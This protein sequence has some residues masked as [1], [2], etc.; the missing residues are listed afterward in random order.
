[1]ERFSSEQEFIYYCAKLTSQDD[2]S[3]SDIE[4]FPLHSD[5]PYYTFRLMLDTIPFE[6]EL[7]KKKQVITSGCIRLLRSDVCYSYRNNMDEELLNQ[8]VEIA[9]AA[10][11]ETSIDPHMI[12]YFLYLIKEDTLPYLFKEYSSQ[13]QNQDSIY[14]SK[15]LW[16]ITNMIRICYK[17]IDFVTQLNSIIEDILT[18]ITSQQI[19]LAVI[20]KSLSSF[21]S[22]YS[23]YSQNLDPNPQFHLLEI[24]LEYMDLFAQ[25]DLIF[26]ESGNL[27]SSISY[28]FMRFDHHFDSIIKE[29]TNIIHSFFEKS[30]SLLQILLSTENNS[31]VQSS[32][33]YVLG[34]L[35]KYQTDE[36]IQAILPL[37]ILGLVYSDF[38]SI[39]NDPEQFF[40]VLFDFNS[41]TDMYATD[42]DLR[43]NCAAYLIKLYNETDDIQHIYDLF[44]IASENNKIFEFIYLFSSLIQYLIDINAKMEDDVE[45]IL[46]ALISLSSESEL[47]NCFF[48][49]FYSILPFFGNL[50]VIPEMYKHIQ[51]LVNVEESIVKSQVTLLFRAIRNSI[52]LDQKEFLNK[53]TFDNIWEAKDLILNNEF[54]LTC[55]KFILKLPKELTVDSKIFE[56]AQQLVNGLYDRIFEILNELNDENEKELEYIMNKEGNNI[57]YILKSIPQCAVIPEIFEKQL[58]V[59]E[60]I[61]EYD[62]SRDG[63]VSAVSPLALY[64]EAYPFYMQYMFNVIDNFG[65][66]YSFFIYDI[67]RYLYVLFD[68]NPDILEIIDGNVYIVQNFLEK[69]IPL[70]N[71]D[72]YSVTDIDCEFIMMIF[73]KC[74][75]VGKGLTQESKISLLQMINSFDEKLN[76]KYFDLVK[77]AAFIQNEYELDAATIMNVMENVQKGKY[78][79]TYERA[80]ISTAFDKINDNQLCQIMNIL[81]KANYFGD[82]TEGYKFPDYTLIPGFSDVDFLDDDFIE[83]DQRMIFEK[84]KELLSHFKEMNE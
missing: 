68:K 14:T 58:I 24:S 22:M 65:D 25:P 75:F 78:P 66:T 57:N 48:F 69:F 63:L 46:A 50:E 79:Y 23:S 7:A 30:I 4:G 54:E 80:L 28:F 35:V 20:Q 59:L 18:R 82:K 3:Q 15:L 42:N 56:S 61:R 53:E 43:T 73:I 67:G 41:S 5:F 10:F 76:Q 33:I 49:L 64:P 71:N 39:L 45:D 17:D 70:T 36:E 40:N 13:Y 21:F 9:I 37:L 8:T 83:E 32:L 26:T 72:V 1:M 62:Y 29:N 2:V 51:G 38:A 19:E 6:G 44:T 34:D 60:K 16:I 81:I 52:Y 27:I 31:D 55:S 74:L 77:L 47:K 84:H 11:N 12:A